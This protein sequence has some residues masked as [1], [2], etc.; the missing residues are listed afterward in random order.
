MNEIPHDENDGNNAGNGQKT[1]AHDSTASDFLVVGLGASA[2]GI[3]ALKTF[4]SNVPP[5]S[6]VAY[7]VILHLSPERES[8][9]AEILQMAASIPVDQVNENIVIE[10][11]HVYVI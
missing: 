1:V 7:V 9:L 6:N 4:F 5:D 3:G 2:G 10:P 11:N 8:N